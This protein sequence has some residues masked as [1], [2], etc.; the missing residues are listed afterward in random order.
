MQLAAADVTPPG[1]HHTTPSRLQ[2]VFFSIHRIEVISFDLSST[3]PIPVLSSVSVPWRA[4]MHIFVR[5]K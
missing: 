5:H 3:L 1:H 4:A 2:T